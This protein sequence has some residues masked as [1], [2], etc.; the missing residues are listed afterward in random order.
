MSGY[1]DQD[2][3]AHAASL[4]LSDTSEGD[5]AIRNANEL[6]QQ[7]QPPV[8]APA[9]S[10][11]SNAEI[12]EPVLVVTSH[13][14]VDTGSPSECVI[15]HLH[16]FLQSVVAPAPALDRPSGPS[17]FCSCRRASCG[18]MIA[19]DNA[20]CEYGWFHFDCVGLVEPPRGDWYCSDCMSR[21]N[22]Q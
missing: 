13:S 21:L 8:Q 1:S 18:A 2:L 3:A 17:V 6:A 19:C 22:R 20:N 14:A 10:V 9:V 12:V 15:L 5:N 4:R 7:V 11:R 16:C